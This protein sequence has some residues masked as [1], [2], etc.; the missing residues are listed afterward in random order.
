M[1]PHS[2]NQILQNRKIW[3]LTR[4]SFF[5]SGRKQRAKPQQKNNTQPTSALDIAVLNFDT[6]EHPERTCRRIKATPTAWQNECFPAVKP[7]KTKQPFQ[8]KTVPTDQTDF[9]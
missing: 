5:Q 7:M 2:L 6:A 3:G 4:K 8:T 1:A 9:I